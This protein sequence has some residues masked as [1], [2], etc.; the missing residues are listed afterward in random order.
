MNWNM[1][2]GPSYDVDGYFDF[3]I[4]QQQPTFPATDAL[5]F[6][7]VAAFPMSGL[8]AF[9]PGCVLDCPI[10]TASATASIIN[11][12]AW[13][14]TPSQGYQVDPS[15]GIGAYLLQNPASSAAL[16]GHPIM[17]TT[18][19]PQSQ[20]FDPLAAVPGT[21]TSG[22]LDASNSF[23]TDGWGIQF[24]QAPGFG[25]V[26]PMVP[27]VAFSALHASQPTQ[28]SEQS[29]WIMSHI[30]EL[31]TKSDILEV[32][33]VVDKAVKG[34]ISLGT[35]ESLSTSPVKLQKK[36]SDALSYLAQLLKTYRAIVD[37]NIA[38]K[39]NFNSVYQSVLMV[40]QEAFK[41]EGV[42]ER[43]VQESNFNYA[44]CD[45]VLR[46]IETVHGESAALSLGSPILSVFFRVRDL[47]V[48]A[49]R[50]PH[51]FIG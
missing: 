33:A 39:Q 31:R 15:S 35:A 7:G 45:R 14:Q 43:A 13:N 3:S 48:A 37:S 25:S 18:G 9:D 20:L 50:G 51:G 23:F 21:A 29:Q 16:L 1:N 26:N 46:D 49:H 24:D 38:L 36:S 8:D 19:A 17:A 41:L 6:G 47:I 30:H 12:T 5:V 28:R 44:F 32:R 4:P 11:P 34:I 10:T 40:L 22:A 27:G 2:P 42:L